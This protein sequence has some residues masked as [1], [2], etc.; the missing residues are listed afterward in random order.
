[1][2][3]LLKYFKLRLDL[4]LENHFYLTQNSFLLTYFK[5][6]HLFS[7]YN[8]YYSFIFRFLDFLFIFIILM[9][10]SNFVLIQP[11]LYIFLHLTNDLCHSINSLALQCIYIHV[12]HF[13]CL[14]LL[15]A[16]NLNQKITVLICDVILFFIILLKFVSTQN[17]YQI[18]LHS[19]K[20]LIL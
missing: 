10:F 8:F 16:L 14:D 20:I 1:M 19:I 2:K 7:S 13:N 17:F 5:F 9:I 18:F 11:L 12:L 4:D 6:W 15:S 3:I